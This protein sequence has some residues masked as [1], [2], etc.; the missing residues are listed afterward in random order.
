MRELGLRNRDRLFYIFYYITSE[1]LSVIIRHAG[2]PYKDEPFEIV[3]R[4]GP[5][6]PDSLCDGIS[7]AISRGLSHYYMDHFG[8]ILHHNVDKVL[9][10]GGKSKPAFGG[11]EII[12]PMSIVI[13]G[14]A[15]DELEGVKIPTQDIAKECATRFLKNEVKMLDDHFTVEPRLGSGS[16]E[17]RSLVKSVGANDTSMGVGF[18]PLSHLEEDVL[19]IDRLA[20]SVHGAGEDCKVMA[21]RTGERAQFTVADAIVSKYVKN[22]DDYAD[23]KA[24]IAAK[25]IAHVSARWGDSSVIVNA[26]DHGNDIYL[27]V[28]GTS[29]EMGDDGETGR[30]NRANGLIT[31]GRPMTMEAHAGKNPVNHVGKIYNI[32]AIH[33]ARDIVKLG[34]IEDAYV[35]LV[36]RIGSPIDKPQIKAATIHGEAAP[37][38]IEYAIDYWLEQTPRFAERWI[39]NE[40]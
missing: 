4:K 26:A 1:V 36:S 23:T 9:L 29:A 3:E 39:N 37:A 34:G 22:M 17:L 14:R 7:D 28:T 25:V 15:T 8:T 32:I 2:T 11:G 31:P 24:N 30:G 38:K 27:T 13:G 19:E 18:A 12:R 21:V 40:I 5:G 35:F 16:T 6:H 20:R 10:I 33:A